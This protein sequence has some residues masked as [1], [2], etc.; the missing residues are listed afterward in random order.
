MGVVC[1]AFRLRAR[2]CW[3]SKLVLR[4]VHGEEVGLVQN[5]NES[6]LSP[7]ASLTRRVTGFELVALVQSRW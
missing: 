5:P 2:F 1:T 7:S 4:N 6:R 3:D